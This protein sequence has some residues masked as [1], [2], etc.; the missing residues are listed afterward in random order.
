MLTERHQSRTNAFTLVEL[1]IVVAIIAVISAFAVPSIL[2]ARLTAN[3]VAALSELKGMIS[4]VEAYRARFGELPADFNDLQNAGYAEKF[5]PVTVNAAFTEAY[6]F[7]Y[8]RLGVGGSSFLARAQP[9]VR[10][11]TGLRDFAYI[12]ATG[13]QFDPAVMYYSDDAGV[14]WH[15]V[16]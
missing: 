11:E 1:M 10:G 4:E 2:T 14:N 7:L 6:M 5:D 9:R 13:T 12:T 16:E 8:V 15:V 3:G